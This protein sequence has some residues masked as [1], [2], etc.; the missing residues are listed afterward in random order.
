MFIMSLYN[1]KAYEISLGHKLFKAEENVE[2]PSAS[3]HLGY[4]MLFLVKT[5]S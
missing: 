4:F 2:I 3:F 1:E 5:V